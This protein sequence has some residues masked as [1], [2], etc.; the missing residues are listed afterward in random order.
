MDRIALKI[1]VWGFYRKYAGLLFVLFLLFFG[2]LKGREHIA[3]A[4]FLIQ[5]IKNLIF[6]FG[7]M[8]IYG[9]LISYHNHHF[10]LNPK[11]RFIRDI[12]FL[13]RLNRLKWIGWGTLWLLFPVNLYGIF[14]LTVAV[15]SGKPI[16]AS[17]IFIYIILLSRILV[18]F[19]NRKIIRP[20]ERI[21]GFSWRIS[22]PR[23]GKWSL[24]VFVLRHLILHRGLFFLF[25]K[26]FSG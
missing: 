20:G 1:W 16:S 23:T 5:D 4:Q 12:I 17:L 8:G 10:I 13:T 9:I 24:T 11:N 3:I 21:Y 2:F 25:T 19:F 18:S 7:G 6:P 26:L 22:V 15:V 14:L